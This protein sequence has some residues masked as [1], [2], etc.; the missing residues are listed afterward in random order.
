VA[1]PGH[2]RS[3]NSWYSN[4]R[5]VLRKGELLLIEPNGD[6]ELLKPLENGHFRIGADPGSPERIRFDTLIEGRA[7][8]AIFSGCPYYRT[9]TP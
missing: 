1:Y 2:Y 8:R 6:E 9:F 4:F 3:H 7:D 5:V